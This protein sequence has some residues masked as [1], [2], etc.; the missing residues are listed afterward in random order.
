MKDVRV[1]EYVRKFAG[2][3]GVTVKGSLMKTQLKKPDTISERV[4]WKALQNLVDRFRFSEA[5]GKT[6]MGEMPRSTYLRGLSKHI[7]KLDRDKRE[8][9]SYLLGIYK[10]LNIL[11]TDQ[12]QATTWIDRVNSLPPFNGMTPRSYI[13][14]G[15]LVRLAEVRRFLDFYRGY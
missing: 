13:M 11:F 1:S 8:R 14:E 9:I 6:L 12:A 4:A 7:G 5:E 15:S 3:F 10:A 2:Y